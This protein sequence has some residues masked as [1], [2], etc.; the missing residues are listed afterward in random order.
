MCS[1]QKKHPVTASSLQ[2]LSL[3]L[4]VSV[5]FVCKDVIFDV[6]F[7]VEL[8]LLLGV[9]I[10]DDV[11]LFVALDFGEPGAMGSRNDCVDLF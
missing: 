9:G 2:K 5:S 7:D 11:I 10:G 3:H 6:V 8:F 4:H 1:T